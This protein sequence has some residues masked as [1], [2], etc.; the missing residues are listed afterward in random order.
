MSGPLSSHLQIKNHL[1]LALV[2]E[3]YQHLLAHLDRVKL[4]VG[5]IVY[6]AGEEIHVVYF[7]ETAVVSL[8]AMTEDGATTEVG[9]IG[10]EGMVGLN[11]FL[12]GVSTHEE[13]LVQVA[14]TALRMKA[15]V[16][17]HELRQGS[18]LQILLLRYTRTFIAL[19]SQSVI[20]SQ[21]HTV[22]QR[23]ARW[24]LM[25]HDYVDSDKLLLTQEL[26]AGML[27]SRRAGVT[28]AMR[29][30]REEGLIKNSRG[31]VTILDRAGLESTS[32]ECYGVIREEFD[33]LHN[34]QFS[35]KKSA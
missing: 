1:L 12:V 18:P 34:S 26:I 2:R 7:P 15:S 9:I 6:K 10:R 24:L 14:G 28:D 8:L 30:M 4:E 21:Q 5:E 17:R 19:I 27:G 31:L 25:I 22:G 33:R 11:V 32:C 35:E 16:L 13:A 29:A 20:C 3:E 23:L